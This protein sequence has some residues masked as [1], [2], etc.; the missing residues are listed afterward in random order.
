MYFINGV[1]L[2]LYVSKYFETLRA[3]QDS[4]SKSRTA[5]VALESKNRKQYLLQSL[6]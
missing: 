6:S 5:E 3:F 1:E 2:S 4:V